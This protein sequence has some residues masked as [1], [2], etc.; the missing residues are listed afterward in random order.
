MIE[1]GTQWLN[2]VYSDDKLIIILEVKS[3]EYW[4]E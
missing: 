1:F 4:I 3:T 2:T